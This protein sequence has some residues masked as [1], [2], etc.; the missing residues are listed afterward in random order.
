MNDLGGKFGIPRA[1]VQRYFQ[2]SLDNF[3]ED[4]ARALS[5]PIARRDARTVASDISALGE[6]PFAEIYSL[7]AKTYEN[8]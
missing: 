1:E 4:P 8:N 3:R 7:F 2:A 6:D 5:G